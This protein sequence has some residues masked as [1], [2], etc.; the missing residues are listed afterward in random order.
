MKT[1]HIPSTVD[2]TLTPE[3]ASQRGY[4]FVNDVTNPYYAFH[5]V[6]ELA[7]EKGFHFG[8]SSDDE[9]CG[10]RFGLYRQTKASKR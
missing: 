3:N 2:L 8:S 7:A 6:L 10:A 1:K 9:D 5:E 4:A